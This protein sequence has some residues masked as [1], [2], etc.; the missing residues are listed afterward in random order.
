M[1][2]PSLSSARIIPVMGRC[3]WLWLCFNSKWSGHIPNLLVW[4]QTYTSAVHLNYP[5]ITQFT[6]WASSPPSLCP[7]ILKF[8]LTRTMCL[9][10]LHSKFHLRNVLRCQTLHLL[11]NLTAYE[12]WIQILSKSYSPH[13]KFNCRNR[14]CLPT[15]HVSV[16][17]A[18][19]SEQ[20][21][22]VFS[23]EVLTVLQKKTRNRPFKDG[24]WG[25]MWCQG[26]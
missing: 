19:H 3:A 17:G 26:A 11:L 21:D 10:H 2:P 20:K 15:M 18:S 8:R 25:S 24:E 7:A 9:D 23:S 5:V 14:S 1:L 13:L 22:A 4:R 6:S 12:P 16:P